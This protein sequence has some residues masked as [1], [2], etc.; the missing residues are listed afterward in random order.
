MKKNIL[1]TIGTN[2]YNKVKEIEF[3]L[4]NLLNIN[5]RILCWLKLY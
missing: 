1:S 4:V 5:S 3:K 2:K